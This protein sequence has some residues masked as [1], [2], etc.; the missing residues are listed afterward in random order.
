M[1]RRALFALAFAPSR[2]KK[3][4][5]DEELPNQT[6]ALPKELPMAVPADTARLVFHAVPLS[7]KGLLSQQVRDA[8]K[9]LL[10]SARGAVPVRLRAM[11]AGT[12]DLRR[13]PAIVSELFTERHLPL[14]VLTVV[15]VGALPLEGAQVAIE[16]VSV[17]RKAANPSGLAFIGARGVSTP[18]PLDSVAPLADQALAE[19]RAALADAEPLSITCFASALDSSAQSAFRA[20]FPRAAWHYVQALRAP[21]RAFLE[22]EAVA[23][24]TSPAP[25]GVEIRENVALVSTPRIIFSGGQAGFH[26]G[27]SDIRLAFERLDRT[28]A[29]NR[30]GLKRIVFAR[31]YTLTRGFAERVRSVDRTVFDAGRPPVISEIQV[32]GLPGLDAAFCTDVV[33]LPDNP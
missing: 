21:A 10:S 8:V 28:L 14:P 29:A 17:G 3:K 13:V 20:A 6:L 33:A 31:H 1:T 11:V 4:K 24:L 7:R 15:Q 5:Q 32:E 19:L 12:G 27:D 26:F 18:N 25:G 2:K 16:A 22:C 30:S 23:R 9:S